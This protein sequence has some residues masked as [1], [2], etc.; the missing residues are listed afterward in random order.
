[1]QHAADEYQAC[2]ELAQRINNATWIAIASNNIGEALLTQGEVDDA[3]DGFN[4]AV[5]TY[6]RRGDPMIIAG[7]AL[8]NLSRA[9]LQQGD[10]DTQWNFDQQH[11]SRK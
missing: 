2:L 10:H 9:H 3:I 6:E 11:Q 8:V 4:T 7:A 5:E 1:M